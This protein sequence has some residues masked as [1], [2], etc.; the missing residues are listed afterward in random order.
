MTALHLQTMLKTLKWSVCYL[1]I[2]GVE[3]AIRH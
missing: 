3:E 1:M 2:E